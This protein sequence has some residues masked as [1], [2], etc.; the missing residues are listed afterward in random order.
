MQKTFLL[1]YCGVDSTGG[2]SSFTGKMN[3]YRLILGNKPTFAEE[4]L[5]DF[6]GLYYMIL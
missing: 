4:C 6:L 5:D 1:W 2:A 3:F